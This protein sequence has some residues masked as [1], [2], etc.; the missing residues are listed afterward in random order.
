VKAILLSDISA[1]DE[2]S[3]AAGDGATQSGEK[4]SWFAQKTAI[5]QRDVL[6]AN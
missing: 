1:R 2:D 4:I 6:A 3:R 5:A